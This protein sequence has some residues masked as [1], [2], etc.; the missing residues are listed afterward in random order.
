VQSDVLIIQKCLK[1]FWGKNNKSIS[2]RH[3]LRFKAQLVPIRRIDIKI[4]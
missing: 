2:Q 1:Q 3:Y 4:R